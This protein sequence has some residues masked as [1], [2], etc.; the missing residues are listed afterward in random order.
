MM[1]AQY[2]TIVI[3]AGQA[4]LAAGYYLA[5]A[6]R[7]FV[8]LDGGEEIGAA[9]RRRWDS[10]RLFT[11]ARYNALPGLPFPGDPRALP[12]KDDV[13]DYLQEYA[14][15]F[16]LPV[17]F[18]SPVAELSG[19]E[20][21][22]VVRTND[23]SLTASSVIV[24]TGGNQRPRIPD[25]AHD[26]AADIVQL[27]SSA[28]RRP[29]QIPDGPVLVVGAGNSGAQIALELAAS[30]R[31][32]YL[33]GPDTG[34]LPRTLLGLDV[35]DWLW[36]TLMRPRIDTW[37]GR[38]ILAGRFAAADPLIG[39]SPRD[40]PRPRLTRTGRTTGTRDGRPLLDD[41]RVLG[42]VTTVI[43]CTGYRPDFHWIRFPIFNPDGYPRH[44]GG[45]VD[46][47]R[48][49]AFLGL[50]YQSR[51]GSALLGGVGEDA[52]WVVG[53]IAHAAATDDLPPVIPSLRRI[54]KYEE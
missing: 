53:R 48:G 28:Y 21:Q 8:L 23:E 20:G 45:L 19:E 7:R 14:R 46:T 32:V 41:G 10:L 26:L 42:D 22:F 25:F 54:S 34:S 16:E 50:R 15:R 13:A 38:R 17:R 5:R 9:W 2:D 18:R 36:P 35:Y 30:N 4:G 31:H 29:A 3:G 6:G 33:S 12:G 44:H 52:E 1:A 47:P 27:H 39:L 11:P 49:L 40:L 37:L 24:A 43:W 51:M